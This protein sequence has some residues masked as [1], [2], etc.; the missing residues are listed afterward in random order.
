MSC[1][2]ARCAE[3]EAR[4]ARLD[5]ENNAL[6][7]RATKA[8]YILRGLP[9]D[10]TV[11]YGSGSNALRVLELVYRDMRQVAAE[12]TQGYFGE[13]SS[14]ESSVDPLPHTGTLNKATR[15]TAR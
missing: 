10:Y 5:A 7:T 14:R 3:L 15:G 13:P 4:T 12:L 6:R 8:A 2:G 11:D 9:G 1:S